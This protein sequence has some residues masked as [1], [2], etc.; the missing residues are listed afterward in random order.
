MSG[1]AIA[2]TLILVVLIVCTM[3]T[4]IVAMLLRNHGSMGAPGRL[5]LLILGR[6]G[7]GTSWEPFVVAPGNHDPDSRYVT[8]DDLARRMS[9]HIAIEHNGMPSATDWTALVR[10]VETLEQQR[11][12]DRIRIATLER[13]VR[14][15][16]V[17]AASKFP[18]DVIGF[19]IGAIVG[20]IVDLELPKHFYHFTTIINVYPL[21]G[22]KY[23]LGLISTTDTLKLIGLAFICA[24]VGYVLGR[25]L[26][27]VL[28]R[29]RRVASDADIAELDARQ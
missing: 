5:A 20:V 26:M 11:E 18:F 1:T 4:I 15:L 7:E 16:R 24:V 29:T 8:P 9:D 23:R 22:Q 10:R 21:G 3:A 25:A 2:I 14:R 12:T 28:G 13:I 6:G 19:F 27:W 17:R